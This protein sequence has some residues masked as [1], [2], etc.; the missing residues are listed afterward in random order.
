M[1]AP[2]LAV[3]VEASP[4]A[5]FAVAVADSVAAVEDSAAAGDDPILGSSTIL[6]CS[7]TS[8]TDLASIASAILAATKPMS[9]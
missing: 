4:V 3:A 2:V 5:G 9:V 7:V 1:V 8:I 6:P